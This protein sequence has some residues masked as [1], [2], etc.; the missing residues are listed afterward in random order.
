MTRIGPSEQILLLLRERLERVDRCEANL[1]GQPEPLDAQARL[2]ALAGL[3]D[4]PQRSFRR[5]IV[6]GL[7][8]ERLG[9]ELAGDSAFEGVVGQVMELIEGDPATAAM[10][11]RAAASLRGEASPG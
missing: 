11:E 10:L 9:E 8:T 1:N 3:K 6:R 4:L 2:A 5:A 7:L